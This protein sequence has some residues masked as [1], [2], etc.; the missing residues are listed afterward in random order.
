MV[1]VMG[2]PWDDRIDKN[3][4]RGSKISVTCSAHPTKRWVTKNIDF[5]GAR[6]VWYIGDVAHDHGI[7]QCQT[8]N[9]M[10]DEALTAANLPLEECYTAS[11]V[12]PCSGTLVLLPEAVNE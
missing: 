5:I 3:V 12:N 2:E 7:R 9:A 8:N 4:D 11:S 1:D 10:T 6:T